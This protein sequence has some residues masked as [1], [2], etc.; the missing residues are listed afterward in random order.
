MFPVCCICELLTFAGS[1]INNWFAVTLP[2]VEIVAPDKF[3]VVEILPI[4]VIVDDEAI[5]SACKLPVSSID[6]YVIAPGVIWF[7]INKPFWEVKDL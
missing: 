1:F 7:C 2:T 4:A 5:V 3:D 6:A